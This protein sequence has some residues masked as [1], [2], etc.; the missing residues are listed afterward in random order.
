MPLLLAHWIHDLDPFL[1][2]WGENFGIRYYGLAYLLGFLGGG[3]LIHLHVSRRPSALRP[4]AVPDLLIALVIGVFLGGRLGYFFLYQPE[5][6]WSDPLRLVRVWEG[7]MASHGG[8]VGVALALVWFARRHRVGFRHLGDLVTAAAPLGIMLGRIANFIN[9][10]LW[11]KVTTVRWGVIF[12]ASAERPWA[13][14]VADLPARHPSQLYA[15]LLEGAV[16]LAFMQHRLWRSDLVSRQPGRLAGEFFVAY[17]L[18]R[19]LTEVF[20]EPDATLILGL[21]R[22]TFYSFFLL[23]AG[24]T[25]IVRAK[26]A[27]SPQR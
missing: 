6:L 27:T 19:A 17:A 7:G 26:H 23:A 12:P 8:M 1:F 16:L 2:R 5:S 11:G 10:E 21:S 13:Q 4:E 25:L 20:R 9:G 24:I 3:W 15:A 18:L 14:A 22:G